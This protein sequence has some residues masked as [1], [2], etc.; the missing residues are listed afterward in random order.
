MADMTSIAA[1]LSSIKAASDIAKLLK[2]ADLSLE[3]AE[4]RLKWADLINAL[5]DARIEAAEVQETLN[6]KDGEIR[7]LQEAL[8]VKTSL[9]YEEPAYWRVEGAKREGPYC[10]QCYDKEGKLI[11]LQGGTTGVYDCKTCNN[12]F[13]TRQFRDEQEASIR[14]AN[15]DWNPV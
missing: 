9:T 7:K 4:L 6:L 14:R 8:S 11:R 5:A 15:H 13:T 2:E 10:Q 1:I 12:T 3:K